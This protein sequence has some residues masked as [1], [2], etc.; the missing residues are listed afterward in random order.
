ML[1]DLALNSH[2]GAIMFVRQ[3]DELFGDLLLEIKLRV[4]PLKGIER[5]LKRFQ[6]LRVFLRRIA[7]KLCVILSNRT[8]QFFDLLTQARQDFHVTL[9]TLDL[10]VENDA[11]EP[12]PAFREFLSKIEMC[13][14]SEAET[15]NV[16]LHDVFRFLNTFR[17]FHF[18]L[19]GQKR[20]LTHLFEIHPDGVV[21][22]VELRLRFFFLL[23]IEVFFYFFMSI[24]IGCFNDVDL[25][26]AESRKNDVQ[27]VRVRYSIRQGLIQIIEG[28]IAL[29]LGKLDE[30][31]K[32]KLNLSRRVSFSF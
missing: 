29:L 30:L 21:E 7:R 3:V 9:A 5:S 24:N 31:A 8:A 28:E 14:R 2:K 4:K 20:H 26:S 11:V 6:S 25:H 19:T 27:L 1:R 13:A 12:F 10:L 15:V 32:T 23:F 16:L 17:D 22:N 18:L